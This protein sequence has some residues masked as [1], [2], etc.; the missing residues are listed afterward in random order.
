MQ[1]HVGRNN[2]QLGTFTPSQILGGLATGQF[3][4]TDNAW[5]DGLDDWKPLS[6]LDVLSQAD[7][8]PETPLAPARPAGAAS[9]AQQ[10]AGKSGDSG[11]KTPA[12]TQQ[13][14][15]A[16]PKIEQKEKPPSKVREW[17]IRAAVFI[18]LMAVAL[19]TAQ[20]VK[21]NVIVSRSESNAV[22]L[23]EA[24]HA[25][26]DEHGGYFPPELQTLVNMKLA[27]LSDLA[28]PIGGEAHGNGWQFF[29]AGQKRSREPDKVIVISKETNAA[30][31]RVIGTADGK[32]RLHM[33]PVLPRAK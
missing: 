1:I 8:V 7:L 18:A 6:E 20:F 30:G 14:G 15:F 33:M 2:Q 23:I 11:A 10:P 19:P 31:Q 27:T 21:D 17:A 16:L 32:A 4:P 26:A 3:L 22:K 13:A 9:R 25:Y 5:H 12:G 28:C 29:A 24:C